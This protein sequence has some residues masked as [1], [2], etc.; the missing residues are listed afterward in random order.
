MGKIQCF[1]GGKMLFYFWPVFDL[2]G[3]TQK[4][5][6]DG[7]FFQCLFNLKQGLSG[8]NPSATALSQDFEFFLCP[9]MT[10]TPLSF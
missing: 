10:F 6:D 9:T 7:P 5:A 1:P 3:I 8:T 4:V 2:C